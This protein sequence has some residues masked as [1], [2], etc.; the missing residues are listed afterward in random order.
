MIIYKRIQKASTSTTFKEFLTSFSTL[1]NLLDQKINAAKYLEHYV[2]ILFLGNNFPLS[3]SFLEC[4]RYCWVGATKIKL[5][6]I[7]INKKFKKL[8]VLLRKKKRNLSKVPEV[9]IVRFLFGKKIC[10]IRRMLC[11]LLLR[12]SLTRIDLSDSTQTKI[13]CFRYKNLLL[14]W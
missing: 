9:P 12:K 10:T 2:Q 14:R 7:A 11:A 1:R 5:A 8:F 13:D 6:S 3:T 4:M